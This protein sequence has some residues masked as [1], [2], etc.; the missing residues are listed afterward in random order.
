[1]IFELRT[2][3]VEGFRGSR[4]FSAAG[5]FARGACCPALHPRFVCHSEERSDEESAFGFPVLVER[6][7]KSRCFTS[8]SMTHS[9]LRAREG[10]GVL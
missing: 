10:F 6:V 5:F 2:T 4:K 3:I 1:M 7:E 9:K 8:F